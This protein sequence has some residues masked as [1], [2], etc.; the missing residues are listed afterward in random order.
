MYPFVSGLAGDGIAVVVSRRVL[1]LARQPYYRWLS[2]P[3]TRRELE[4]VYRANALFDAHRGDP[5]FGYRRLVDEG[6]DEDEPVA[7]R[8]AW[9]IASLN[10]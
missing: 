4:E 9:P 2:N 5:K 10:G 3:V 1:T 7:E 6:R 8:T